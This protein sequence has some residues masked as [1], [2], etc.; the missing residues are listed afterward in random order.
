V[1]EVENFS[2]EGRKTGQRRSVD[3][4]E[5]W[6]EVGSDKQSEEIDLRRLEGK[7]RV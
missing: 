3:C 5:G 7:R 2:E 1:E 6:R 4:D